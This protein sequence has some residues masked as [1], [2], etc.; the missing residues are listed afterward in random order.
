MC[1]RRVPLS[2]S[3]NSYFKDWFKQDA[4]KGDF[5]REFVFVWFGVFLNTQEQEQVLGGLR[6][7]RR[8][9][10]GAWGTLVLVT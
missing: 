3:L 10:I 4:V 2:F 5:L 9:C 1:S 7:S 6:C 8:S